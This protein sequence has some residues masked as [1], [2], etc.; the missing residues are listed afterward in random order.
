MR[1]LLI[2]GLVAIA[3]AVA[4][5]AAADSL[6]TGMRLA[7]RCADSIAQ[8]ND[9]TGCDLRRLPDVIDRLIAVWL[10]EA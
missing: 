5:A 3:R 4:F 6:T 7:D 9:D 1:L 2:H 10:A 8:R